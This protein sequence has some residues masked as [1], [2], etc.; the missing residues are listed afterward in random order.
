MFRARS[1]M[2]SGLHIKFK[3]NIQEDVL[4]SMLLGTVC[5]PIKTH[6]DEACLDQCLVF[7]TV[8]NNKA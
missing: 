1:Q 7:Y 3:F 6:V 5:C 8:S 2:L 4:I